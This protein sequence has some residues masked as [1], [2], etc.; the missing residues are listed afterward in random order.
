M[1][2]ANFGCL[3]FGCL[4]QLVFPAAPCFDF[5]EKGTTHQCRDLHHIHRET[6]H[7]ITASEK[8]AVGVSPGAYTT[9]I[10]AKRHT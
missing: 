7:S 9:S 6:A 8:L 10:T 3:G 2:R 1:T 4:G 5:L